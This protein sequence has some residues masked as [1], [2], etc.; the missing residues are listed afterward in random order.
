MAL[1]LVT[2]M[3]T[4][5]KIYSL[6]GHEPTRVPVVSKFLCL[7]PEFHCIL[8]PKR[9]PHWLIL[10]TTR[11]PLIRGTRSEA[12]CFMVRRYPTPNSYL[13]TT[14]GNAKYGRNISLIHERAKG[15]CF[16]K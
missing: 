5:N 3:G 4:G 6:P 15:L 8:R 9:E 11:T 2:T 1:F 13:L 10:L 14:S 7:C 12:P 16:L